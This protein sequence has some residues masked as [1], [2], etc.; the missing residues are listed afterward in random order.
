MGSFYHR[1]KDSKGP[2]KGI[3]GRGENRIVIGRVKLYGGPQSRVTPPR[4]DLL[5]GSTS[6]DFQVSDEVS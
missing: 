2:E 5:S 3:R 4:Q 1:T 6:E